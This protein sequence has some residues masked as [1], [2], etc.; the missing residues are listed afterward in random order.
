MA[1]HRLALFLRALDNRYQHAQKSEFYARAHA[2]RFSVIEYDAKN[3]ADVQLKQI[4][5]CLRG[6]EAARPRALFVNPVRE[7]LLELAAKEGASLGIG[8]VSLNRSC[9]YVTQ[10]RHR[11]P[12]IPFAC[13]DPDQRQAG[14]FQAQQLRL[15]LPA[16][17]HALY[18]HGPASTSS[19][20]LRRS[21]FDAGLVGGSIQ[22]M[23]LGGDWSE[24]SGFRAV[25][26]W[27]AAR[28]NVPWRGLAVS[29]Q[30]DSMAM[31]ASRALHEAA[32]EYGEPAAAVVPIT[33]CDGLLSYGQRFVG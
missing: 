29:S 15:L 26:D 18:V 11:Y 1:N 23:P 20:R 21:G 17:G 9:D 31:G 14:L 28:T 32:K 22:V 19:S 2:H 4:R 16:G 30:N 5:D 6:P 10:L 24:E 27:I 13:V 8:W 25:K 7:A 33:G 12:G 3:D